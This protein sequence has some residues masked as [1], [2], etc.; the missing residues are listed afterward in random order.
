MLFPQIWTLIILTNQEFNYGL[1][2]LHITTLLMNLFKS[3]KR[4]SKF[5]CTK[6]K[7]V[8]KKAFF[9]VRKQ[10]TSWSRN[11]CFTF[12]RIGFNVFILML[13]TQNKNRN[14]T[15][16][17]S[18]KL[19]K[20]G[21]KLTSTLKKIKGFPKHNNRNEITAEYCCSRS[22]QRVEMFRTELDIGKNRA[23]P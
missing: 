13:F 6:S 12:I 9:F 5:Q 14:F 20:Q 3:Y 2:S 1:F 17:I 19:W 21:I 7:I 23:V 18:S 16:N 8:F 4:T 11:Y 15:E 10:Y 22:L